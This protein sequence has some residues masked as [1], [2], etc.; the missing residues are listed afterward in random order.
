MKKLNGN[1][2]HEMMK[3]NHKFD[4]FYLYYVSKYDKNET[5]IRRL[6]LSG[7]ERLY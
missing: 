3:K 4:T 1:M 7:R 5:P 6:Y 2:I